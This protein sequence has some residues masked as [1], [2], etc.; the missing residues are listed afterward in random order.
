M[1]TP[2]LRKAVCTELFLALFQPKGYNETVKNLT[3]SGFTKEV[4]YE[5]FVLSD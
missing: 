3:K 1:A 5:F 2:A 4:L